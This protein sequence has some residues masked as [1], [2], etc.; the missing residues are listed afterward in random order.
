[1]GEKTFFARCYVKSELNLLP[2]IQISISDAYF[3]AVELEVDFFNTIGQEAGIQPP[4]RGALLSKAAFIPRAE[5]CQYELLIKLNTTAMSVFRR[6]T[7]PLS[8]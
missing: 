2:K 5:S 7:H 8:R 1:M 4:R 6:P 3:S